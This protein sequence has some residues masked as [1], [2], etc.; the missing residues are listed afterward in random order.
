MLRHIL[1][2]WTCCDACC[3]TAARL[4]C[5]CAAC[6]AGERSRGAE[7]QRRGGHTDPGGS[8]G[9]HGQRNGRAGSGPAQGG[10]GWGGGAYLLLSGHLHSPLFLQLELL[11]LRRKL[12]SGKMA[13]RNKKMHPQAHQ[14]GPRPQGDRPQVR[15][16]AVRL[17]LRPRLPDS[18]DHR[19][20]R[21]AAV[22]EA[23]ASAP[24]PASWRPGG[25]RTSGRARRH[26]V[27]PSRSRTSRPRGSGA[28]GSGTSSG[29]GTRKSTGTTAG[30]PA[31]RRPPRS[32][33]RRSGRQRRWPS[34]GGS[35][36]SATTTSR[37]PRP[38]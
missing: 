6:R 21:I 22:E 38:P 2:S 30:C 28:T 32:T 31:Q 26:A 33:W 4:A 5:G 11:R 10:G 3:H 7:G 16:G 27:A 15:A 35:K 12:G 1:T 13:E 36:S 34:G 24:L 8:A 14:R 23:G 20:A 37:S 19:A 18:T 17:Q 25:G 29:T 9:E